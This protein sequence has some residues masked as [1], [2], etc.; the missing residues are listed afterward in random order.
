MHVEVAGVYG[1]PVDE[2]WKPC[3]ALRPLP[4]LLLPKSGP[5]MPLFISANSK[6]YRLK[7]RNREISSACSECNWHDCGI[8]VFVGFSC[9]FVSP[10]PCCVFGSFARGMGAIECRRR[11]SRRRTPLWL[12]S[13]TKD[14]EVQNV[15]PREASN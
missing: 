6:V 2:A 11:S 10:V 1:E 14:A 9:M 3:L 8:H 12:I 4:V 15:E 13:A 7:T 5:G